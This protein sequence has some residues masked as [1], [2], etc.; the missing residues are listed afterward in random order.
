MPKKP[1]P[2]VSP[3]LGTASSGHRLCS[4][5]ACLL[6]QGKALELETCH[7]LNHQTSLDFPLK[8]K[9]TTSSPNPGWLLPW[10]PTIDQ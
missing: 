2:G 5:L 7:L 9:M 10:T 8:K 1:A 6:Y 4:L 3:Q